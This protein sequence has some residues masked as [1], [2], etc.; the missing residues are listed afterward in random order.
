MPD[1]VHDDHITLDIKSD[2][3]PRLESRALRIDTVLEPAESYEL[4]G[5]GMGGCEDP[6]ITYLVC[7]DIYVMAYTGCGISGPHVALATSR[8]LRTRV[9]LGCVGL[10]PGLRPGTARARLESRSEFP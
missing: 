10:R 6:R 3:E 4:V 2:V 1:L 5:P 7:A 9:R 8:D